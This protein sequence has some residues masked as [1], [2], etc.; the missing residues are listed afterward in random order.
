MAWI[1]RVTNRYN[2]TVKTPKRPG[3]IAIQ[4][5][6]ASDHSMETE[7]RVSIGRGDVT[8][9]VEWVGEGPSRPLPNRVIELLTGQS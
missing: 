9:E 4:T 8:T 3:D 1:W 2:G 5:V 6:H 7:V